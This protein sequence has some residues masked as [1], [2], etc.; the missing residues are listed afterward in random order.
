MTLQGM[1][2]CL[3]AEAAPPEPQTGSRGNS[4]QLLGRVGG[5]KADR[6]VDC[7]KPFLVSTC[8]HGALGTH[9]KRNP[10]K[11]AQGGGTDPE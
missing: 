9:P 6:M 4:Y 10:S 2:T 11:Y 1:C 5:G 3:H 7:H 8:V